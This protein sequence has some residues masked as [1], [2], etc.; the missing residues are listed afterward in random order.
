MSGPKGMAAVA[1]S[2]V[3]P[4]KSESGAV[5][6]VPDGFDLPALELQALSSLFVD[7][8]R[9]MAATAPG[10]LDR[11]L[12]VARVRLQLLDTGRTEPAVEHESTILRLKI[13]LLERGLGREQTQL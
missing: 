6:S 13:S 5:D 10:T 1:E 7:L 4:S 3:E 2:G 9:S 8:V 12:Q 11:A